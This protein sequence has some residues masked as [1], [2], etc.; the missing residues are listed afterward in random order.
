[1]ATQLREMVCITCPLGCRMELE[2]V[3]GE[4]RGVQHNSCKRGIEYAKQE[5]YDPRRMVTATATV[6]N[7]VVQR[8]PVRTSEPLPVAH[9]QALLAE[10]YRLTLSAPLDIGAAVIKNFA[11]T[12]VDVVTT[13]SIAAR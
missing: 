6:E 13:R 4:L 5:F 11:D 3:D 10:I 9:I 8:V 7:G 1:M 2:V 12:G